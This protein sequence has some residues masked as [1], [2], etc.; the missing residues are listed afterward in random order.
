VVSEALRKR[1]RCFRAATIAPSSTAAATAGV[2][3]KTTKTFSFHGYYPFIG[4][5][6]KECLVFGVDLGLDHVLVCTVAES[7]LG[8]GKDWTMADTLTWSWLV[9]G[10]GWTAALVGN[11]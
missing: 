7:L 4:N 6:I 11:H 3:C 9:S 1:N 2:S 10:S 8:R 5:P